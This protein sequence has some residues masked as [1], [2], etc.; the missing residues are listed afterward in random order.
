M[1]ILKNILAVVI[2]LFIGVIVNISMVMFSSSVIPPPA[3]SDLTTTEGLQAAMPLME[4]KHFLMPFLAHGFGTLVGAILAASMAV[5][6]KMRFAM[7][8]G[9]CFLAGGIMNIFMLPSPVWFTIVDLGFA[10]IPMAYLG[11]K[12]VLRKRN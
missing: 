12:I 2:S 6:Y 1:T 7:I 4:P 10:Y 5:N 9:I 8:I 11:G 3:G